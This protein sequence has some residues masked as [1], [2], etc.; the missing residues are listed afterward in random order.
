MRLA[1]I[2]F[3]SV[4]QPR[5]GLQVRSRTAAESL[6][7]LGVDVDIVSTREPAGAAAS[8][9]FARSLAVPRRK[10]WR[11]FSPGFARLIRRAARSSDA[12]VVANAMFMP[13]VAA[14]GTRR[15]LIWDTNEC[16]TL[17]YRRLART[18]RN[19]LRLVVWTLLERWAARRCVVA[20]AI[21]ETEAEA[22]RRIHPRLRGK[23]VT[24]DHAPLVVSA[25]ERE[26]PRALLAARLGADLG[27]VL[28]FAGMMGAKH[29]AAA[30]RWLLDVLAPRLPGDATLVICGPGSERL[31]CTAPTRA[32][33]ACLGAVDDIDSLIAAADLCLAPLASGAGVKTKVLHY[34]WHGRRVAGTPVAFEGVEGAPGLHVAELD[35]LPALVLRL[36][37]STAS[38]AAGTRAATDTAGAAADAIRTAQARAWIESHH[39]RERVREQWRSV[40]QWIPSKP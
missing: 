22:W 33:V 4:A 31:Q 36:L 9:P 3:G 5:G 27:R 26:A 21:G 11:G 2:T 29:N 15:P 32:R 38:D 12:L 1:L 18:P 6:A 30:A 39:G 10:P 40:L 19:R 24:I 25:E 14:T 34:L 20:V 7:A 28:L 17:H 16:Q 35:A 37:G 13:A 23:L 8:L